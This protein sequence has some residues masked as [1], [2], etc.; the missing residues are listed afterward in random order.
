MILSVGP[1]KAQANPSRWLVLLYLGWRPS[2]GDKDGSLLLLWVSR[3]RPS[4]YCKENEI[5]ISGPLN[6][7]LCRAIT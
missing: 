5:F 4:S 1:N 6:I 7:N 3:N 2:P